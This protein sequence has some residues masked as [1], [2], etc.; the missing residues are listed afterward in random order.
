MRVPGTARRSNQSIL[1]EINP[2]YSLDRLMQKLQYFGL[3]MLRAEFLENTLMLGMIEV[4]RIRGTQRM[5]WLGSITGSMDK[6]LSKL[7]E[8]V[9]EPG[10]LQSMGSQRVRHNLASKQQQEQQQ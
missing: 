8:K 4:R 2:E 6:N 5:K 3:L 7:W 10:L 1:K 9:E